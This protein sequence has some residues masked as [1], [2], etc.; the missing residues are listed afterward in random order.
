MGYREG[1]REEAVG[2]REGYREEAVRYREGYREDYRGSSSRDRD[3]IKASLAKH[4]QGIFPR[5][6]SLLETMMLWRCMDGPQDLSVKH[7]RWLS[8]LGR[9]GFVAKGFVYAFVGVLTCIS[10]VGNSQNESPQ[11]VFIFV[12]SAPNGTNYVYTIL[13]V[14]GILFSASGS[15]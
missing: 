8:I 10:A 2:Y 15:S 3:R 6:F 9:I 14:T 13:L 11:G 7:R 4:H 12:G 1:Y 5:H